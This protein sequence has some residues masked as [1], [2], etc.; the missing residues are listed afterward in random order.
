[1]PQEDIYMIGPDVN[2]VNHSLRPVLS[3]RAATRF[4]SL[5]REGQLAAA[6]TAF[7][8]LV[9]LA[10]PQYSYAQPQNGKVALVSLQDAFTSIA[11]EVEPTVVTISSSKTLRSVDGR[12]FP[13]GLGAP[14]PRSVGTGTGVV[15]RKDGWILTNDHVVSG[16]DRVLVRFHDGREILGTVRRDPRSDLALVKVESKTPLQ[17]ARFGDSDKVRIGQWAIAIGSPYK[18]EGSF[19]VGVISSLQRKQ[20]IDDPSVG[21]ARLYPNLMQTD[22]ETDA[23]INPGNSGGP[24]CNINGEVVAINCAI[25]SPQSQGGNIGIGFAIPINT[26]RYV[27]N[28]LLEHDG[29]TYGFLGVSP[30]TITPKEAAALKVESGALIFRDPS[31]TSPAG[32]AGIMAGDVITSI[33]G[34]SVRSEIDLRTIVSQTP[35]RTTV[36]IKLVRD[37]VTRIVSATLEKAGDEPIPSSTKLPGKPSLGLDVD[38]LTDSLADS[39]RVPRSTLGVYVKAIDPNSSAADEEA[40]DAGAV[41]LSVNDKETPTVEA[42]HEAVATL[43]SGD[44]VKVTYLRSIQN[45][46]AVRH[47]TVLTVD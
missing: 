1:M 22:A 19:S 35:P 29:V 43:R 41:I 26:A 40:L 31:A 46:G 17:V 33:G 7:L 39:A 10:L 42:F 3:I 30:S 2:F 34:K 14:L 6:S 21:G 18:L 45:E 24:L 27:M 8:L 11:E 44:H 36:D 9:G 4:R 16:A 5:F 25:Q 13:R 23:A 32:K 38:K 37:G 28:Q 12:D 47:F 15:V 20:E